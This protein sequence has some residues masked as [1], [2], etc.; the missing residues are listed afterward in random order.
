MVLDH[1]EAFWDSKRLIFGYKPP[2]SLLSL[3]I[4]IF[5]KS[6]K[7]AN[8]MSNSRAITPKPSEMDSTMGVR[9]QEK[10]GRF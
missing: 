9:L 10:L 6:L 4:M 8:P 2:K 1:L 7:K 5:E 3:K